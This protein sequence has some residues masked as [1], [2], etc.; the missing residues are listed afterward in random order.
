MRTIKLDNKFEV[1]NTH[2]RI[3]IKLLYADNLVLSIQIL[4]Q[5]YRF[6]NFRNNWNFILSFM[7]ESFIFNIIPLFQRLSNN[8]FERLANSRTKILINC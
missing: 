5:F 6:R 8:F 7:I 1:Q 2:R 3:Q 4:S